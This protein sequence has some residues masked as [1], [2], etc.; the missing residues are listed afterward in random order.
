[1]IELILLTIQLMVI[2]MFVSFVGLLW[3]A[4]KA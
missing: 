2:M 3:F 1:M 4:S